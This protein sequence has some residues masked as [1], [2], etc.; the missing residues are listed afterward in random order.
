MLGVRDDP[1]LVQ[2]F[3]AAGGAGKPTLAQVHVC[4][5]ESE[6]SARRTALQWWPNQGIPAALLSDGL[7]RQFAAATQSVTEHDVTASITCG[8]DPEMHATAI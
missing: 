4:W 2:A 5:A 8:P 3:E 7:P 1:S 6:A